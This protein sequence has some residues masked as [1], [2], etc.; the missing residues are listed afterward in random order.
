MIDDARYRRLLAAARERKRP[1]GAL[2]REAIDNAFPATSQRRHTALREI[3]SA[4]RIPVPEPENLKE[5]LDQIRSG[6]L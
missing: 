3:L 2:V 4:P 6:N 5:E 1:V